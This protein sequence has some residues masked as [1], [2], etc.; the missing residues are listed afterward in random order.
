[1]TARN[2]LV[3]AGMIGVL[4][5][6]IVV[7]GVTYDPKSPASTVDLVAAAQGDTLRVSA[8]A[9]AGAFAKDPRRAGR[10]FENRLC[11]VTGQIT[12]VDG[13]WLGEP[14]VRFEGNRAKQIV[15]SMMFQKTE[16][17]HVDLLEIGETISVLGI[18]A[19][20]QPRYGIR[21]KQCM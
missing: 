5:A 12:G 17:G 14:V 11:V 7:Y 3:F 21:F 18:C 16:Q 8:K 2:W 10:V 6:M 20:Q 1:M 15:V 9:L 4:F 19:G 13:N